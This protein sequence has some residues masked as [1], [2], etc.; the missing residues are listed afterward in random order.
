MTGYQGTP[1][2]DSWL[3]T[4]AINASQLKEK[5]MS[6]RTQVNGYGST[7]SKFEVYV[8]TSADPSTATLTKLNPDLPTAPDSGYSSWVNS[9]QLSLA[10][11]SGIIYI[12][13]RYTATADTQYANWCVDDVL[14]GLSKSQGGTTPDDPD[15][16]TEGLGS[17]EKPYKVADVMKTTSD[18]SNVWVEGYIVGWIDGKDYK[19]GANFNNQTSESFNNTNLI[20]A[21]SADTNSVANAIPCAIPTGSMRDKLGLK[22][23]PAIYKK[24]VLIKGTITKYFGQRGVKEISEYVEL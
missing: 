5:V 9:G 12:G 19:T 18:V 23:N 15:T 17:K 22:A 6:F 24:H 4:P 13:F 14:V 16:P 21:P 2:F 10:D 11:F 20:L 3:I 7:T 1:P 8:M